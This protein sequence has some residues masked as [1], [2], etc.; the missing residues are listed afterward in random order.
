MK[1][2]KKQNKKDFVRFFGFLK[3]KEDNETGVEYEDRIRRNKNERKYME[4]L[5]KGIT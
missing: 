2:N 5:R 4:N 1:R 3:R